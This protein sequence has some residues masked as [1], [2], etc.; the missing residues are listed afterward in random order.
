LYDLLLVAFGPKTP[1]LLLS[2]IT[3]LLKI[4]GSY[5]PAILQDRTG[6]FLPGF[7]KHLKIADFSFG[8]D[9]FS[10]GTGKQD[11]PIGNPGLYR[12]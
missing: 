9:T 10:R 7:Q 12:A 5:R 6:F 3:T 4:R 11:R 8:V 2:R 1:F